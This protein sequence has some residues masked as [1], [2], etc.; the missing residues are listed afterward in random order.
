M[1]A[2]ID[3]RSFYNHETGRLEELQ[4]GRFG[5]LYYQGVGLLK[6]TNSGKGLNQKGIIKTLEF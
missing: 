3:G 4:G 2:R 1:R 6:T 5:G